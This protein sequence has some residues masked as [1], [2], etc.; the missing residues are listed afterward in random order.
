MSC[1][2]KNGE[3]C[4]YF[5]ATDFVSP[6]PATPTPRLHSTIPIAA[7]VPTITTNQVRKHLRVAANLMIISLEL[8]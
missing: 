5:R 3:L 8:K 2:K 7:N 6:S 1:Q 4:E